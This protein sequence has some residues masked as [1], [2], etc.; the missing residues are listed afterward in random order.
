MQIKKKDSKVQGGQHFSLE[1]KMWFGFFFWCIL[2]T[3]WRG[4]IFNILKQGFPNF[5]YSPILYHN[6]VNPPPIPH[7]FVKK[8]KMQQAFL[9]SQY[10][11][12][13][14][15]DQNTKNTPNCHHFFFNLRY[16]LVV[17]PHF[18]N[19]WF[20]AMI[21]YLDVS[22]NITRVFKQK[23]WFKWRTSLSSAVT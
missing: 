3:S 1:P 8:K 15:N 5:C 10:V 17:A 2:F 21:K 20:K 19:P 22:C 13:C 12:S 7:T 6:Q 23:W 11:Y 16:P 9:W 4:H 14:S 18:G